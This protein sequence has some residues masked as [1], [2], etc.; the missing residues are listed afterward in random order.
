VIEISTK[1]F[2]DAPAVKRALAKRERRVLGRWGGYAR[3][4]ARSSIKR[5]GHA[6]KEPRKLTRSGKKSKAWV[7][8]LREI[9][10]RPASAPGSPPFT[11][12]GLLRDA[13][14]YGYDRTR[15]SAVAGALASKTDDLAA[16]HEHGGSRFGRHYPARPYMAPAR[17]KANEQLPRFFQE[18]DR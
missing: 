1:M 13:I 4:V 12:S 3:R 8:W 15:G 11:H 18:A 16:L 17:E 6:R 10:D 14:V 5:V 7:K 2:F 9:K